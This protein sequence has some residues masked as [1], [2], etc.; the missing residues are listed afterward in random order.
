VS[1]R[2]WVTVACWTGGVALVTH[3]VVGLT[4]RTSLWWISAGLVALAAGGVRLAWVVARDGL[5]ALTN[6]EE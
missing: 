2:S 1:G 3:G 5:V 4:G 6:E